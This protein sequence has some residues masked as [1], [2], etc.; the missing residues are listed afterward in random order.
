[1]STVSSRREALQ[2]RKG[3]PELSALWTLF[4]LSLRQFLRGQ[5]LLILLGLALL[6]A[7]LAVLIRAIAPRADAKLG[8]AI[9]FFCLFQLVPHALLPLTALLY[10]SGIITDE[11]EGQTLTYLLV[12]PLPKWAL[13]LTKL[14]AA[15]CVVTLLGLAFVVVTDLAT[16]AGSSKF[17]DV[18]PLRVLQTVG[19]MALALLAYTTVFACL[20]MLVQRSMVAGI[21]YIVAIEGIM[22]NMPFALR[23]LTVMYYFRVLVLNWLYLDKDMSNAWSITLSEAPEPYVCVLTLLIVSV[24]TTALAAL[25][26]S[27][28]EF[29]VKT[30]EGS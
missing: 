13:Y 27:Q 30:P 29:H 17:F 14:L 7:G 9:E 16:Y 6:P 25:V 21:V 15:V 22:G 23:K 19:V 3:G 2:A 18:F 8:D 5:R 26:I 10:G 11:Q 24:L 12:R 1:M 20:S 4:T 28:R